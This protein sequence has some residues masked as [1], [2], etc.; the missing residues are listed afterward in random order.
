M[1]EMVV[2]DAF[3]GQALFTPVPAKPIATIAVIQE[4]KQALIRANE[5]YALALA[6][7][8]I[9]YLYNAYQNL[10]RNPTDVELLMFAQANSE[11]CRH[12]IFN[13]QWVIDNES[14][15]ATLFDMIRQTHAAQPEGTVVAYSDN[16]AVMEGGQAMVFDHEHAGTGLAYQSRDTVPQQLL[17][18][19]TPITTKSRSYSHIG[20][21]VC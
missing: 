6:D 15:K 2:D 3:D 8:E 10:Q 19:V 9:D 14:Q 4:G 5:A 12:K 1:T 21:A 13:S 17:H 16:A 20:A 18:E 11:H 7:D